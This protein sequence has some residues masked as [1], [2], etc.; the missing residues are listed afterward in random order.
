MKLETK[1]FRSEEEFIG[2][3]LLVRAF[4][5]EGISGEEI[6]VE[7]WSEAEEF[8]PDTEKCFKLDLYKKDKEKYLLKQIELPIF[9]KKI[10]EISKKFENLVDGISEEA[11]AILSSVM[12]QSQTNESILLLEDVYQA[13]SVV[14]TCRNLSLFFSWQDVI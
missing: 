5:T 9:I 13:Y 14:I 2:N 8:A 3:L 7:L 4:E 1:E 10:S 12:E 11:F 6:L